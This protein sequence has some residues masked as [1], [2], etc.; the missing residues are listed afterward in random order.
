MFIALTGMGL[1]AIGLGAW[2]NRLLLTL[3]T[4]VL[5]LT[6]VW[7]AAAAAYRADWKDTD[8]FVDCWPSCTTYQDASGSILVGAPATVGL[9]LLGAA[10]IGWR[11]RRRSVRQGVQSAPR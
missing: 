7:V 6:G 11:R 9:W 1:V 4:S 8:G 5:V 10:A 2:R 3:T